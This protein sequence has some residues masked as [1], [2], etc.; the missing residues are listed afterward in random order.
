MKKRVLCLMFVLVFCLSACGGGGGKDPLTAIEGADSKQRKE[1]QSVL[2]DCDIKVQSCS[3][4][5]AENMDNEL[6]DAILGSLMTNFAPYDITDEDGNTYRMVIKKSDYSV[7]TI[8]DS[9][10]NFVYGGLS[11]LF[12]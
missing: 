4:V 1:I 7:S 5:A 12:G 8:T 11:G 10:G 9:D 6:G 2:D 3:A